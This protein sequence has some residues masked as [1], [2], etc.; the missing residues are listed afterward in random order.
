M[1]TGGSQES[2]RS[3]G[4]SAATCGLFGTAGTVFTV[5]SGEKLREEHSAIAQEH[6][7]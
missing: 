2:V 1:Q 5:A 7:H 4:Q 3:R 6:N